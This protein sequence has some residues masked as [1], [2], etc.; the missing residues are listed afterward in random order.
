MQV[1]R[2]KMQRTVSTDTIVSLGLQSRAVQRVA[3]LASAY[4]TSERETQNQIRN[5][6]SWEKPVFSTMSGFATMRF[7]RDMHL[8]LLPS[9]QV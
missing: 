3:R 2:S 5:E 1:D 7:L 8:T 9:F 6:D 4:R